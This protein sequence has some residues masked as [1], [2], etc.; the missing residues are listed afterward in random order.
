MTNENERI[1]ILNRIESGD[2][3]VDEGL[4][5]IENLAIEGEHTPVVG[6][7]SSDSDDNIPG[8]F[9]SSDSVSLSEIDDEPEA[10]FTNHSEHYESGSFE[11]RASRTIPPNAQKWRSYWII[12]FWIAVG[13]T[14]LGGL[15]MSQTYLSSGFGFWFV[16]AMLLLLFGLFI[17]VLAWQSRTAPWLHLR[18][19]QR[20]GD[21]PERISFSF[22]IPIRL[23]VW[24]LRVF[25]SFI[26]KLQ[27]TSLDEVLLAVSETTSPENP[28]IIQADEGE[29]GEKVEIYI[30]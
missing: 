21:H 23:T 20:P 27:D 1:Q 14:G 8:P 13:I 16:C 5:L 7:R 10:G 19:K 18:I 25:G 4:Q 22:P 9:S 6:E 28:I 15:L 17:L 11:H 29:D 24:F 26:P 2:I 3:G 30:G 12:P